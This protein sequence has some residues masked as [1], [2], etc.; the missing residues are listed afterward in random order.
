LQY[1]VHPEL[2]VPIFEAAITDTGIGGWCYKR[3]RPDLVLCRSGTLG[4]GRFE[5]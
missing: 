1:H 4:R 5:G 3:I 2:V